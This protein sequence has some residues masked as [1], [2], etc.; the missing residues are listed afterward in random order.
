MAALW[1]WSLTN[2]AEGKWLQKPAWV[3][4]EC[5]SGGKEPGHFR[6]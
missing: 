3:R 2:D 5:G 1:V 4:L 6:E